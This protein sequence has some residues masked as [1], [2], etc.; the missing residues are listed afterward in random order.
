[1][2]R[3]IIIYLTYYINKTIG[4]KYL[5]AF[6]ILLLYY[7]QKLS[8]QGQPNFVQIDSKTYQAYLQKDWKTVMT[9]GKEAL[10][11]DIDY[12]YLRM[13][14]GIAYYEEH[15]Y[16][17]SI[18]HFEKALAFNFRDKYALEYLYYAY[19]LSGRK[20]EAE[21][22]YKKNYAILFPALQK[23]TI[24]IIESIYANYTY[25]K[26]NQSF[27]QDEVF[28]DPISGNEG[29]QRISK[30][31]SLYSAGIIFSFSNRFKLNTSF[32]RL[33]KTNDYFYFYQE[34][35]IAAYN[36][37]ITQ[38]HFHISPIVPLKKGF[39]LWAAYSAL[40]L[41]VPYIYYYESGT[42][43]GYGQGQQ[44]QT[45][46]LVEYTY[47]EKDYV[48]AG[49][50][51]KNLPF[52]KINASMYYSNLNRAS[53][54]RPSLALTYYP[55]GNLNL[56]AASEISYLSDTYSTDHAIIN[57]RLGVKVFD[58]FW[59]E[60]MHTTGNLINYAEAGG[61]VVYNDINILTDRTD[62]NMYIPFSK[63]KGNIYLSYE[64]AS[65]FSEFHS[66]APAEYKNTLKYNVQSI[67][68]GISWNF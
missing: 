35:S 7:S 20:Y 50:I 14:I 28:V 53:Q 32:S 21:I 30:N 41:N 42:G 38:N 66:Y 5:F 51:S 64:Y 59:I 60:G 46:Q 55:L 37:R 27:E 17:K 48:I 13:R 29:D 4:L 68:G 19:L 12:F 39:T 40:S 11:A 57:N 58:K 45:S 63:Y 52:F 25:N 47:T 33:N 16:Q 3:E 2:H 34:N 6:S 65:Y 26:T 56:Y 8:G 18:L 1:M 49:G 24:S 22:L 44:Q 9:I 62:I 31:F 36:Q 67:T 10:K 15:N 23:D 43:S 54:M 61:A